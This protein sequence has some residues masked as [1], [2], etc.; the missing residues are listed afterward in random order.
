MWQNLSNSLMAFA[1]FALG[2]FFQRYLQRRGRVRTSFSQ[3]KLV[4]L[5][6]GTAPLFPGVRGGD[7]VCS[8]IVKLFNEKDTDTGLHDLAIRFT[9]P[10]QSGVVVHDLKIRLQDDGGQHSKTADLG[11]DLPSRKWAIAEIHGAVSEKNVSAVLASHAAILEGKFPHG[12][13]F[14]AV[15][16]KGPFQ[17][18]GFR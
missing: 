4:V 11:I 17:D 8:F 9:S 18:A 2:V 14:H 3:W 10:G 16:A 6:P 1:F 7:A 15:I 13:G 5:P 12:K